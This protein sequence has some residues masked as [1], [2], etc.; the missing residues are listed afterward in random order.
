MRF[1]RPTRTRLSPGAAYAH[2]ARSR[3]HP[4]STIIVTP[5]SIPLRPFTL[6]NPSDIPRWRLVAGR[7]ARSPAAAP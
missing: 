6:A 3:N 5:R 7:A 2:G 4:N 1:F